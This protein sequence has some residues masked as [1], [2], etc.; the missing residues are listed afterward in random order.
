VAE[1]DAIGTVSQGVVTYNVK[2]SLDTQDERVKPGMSASASII[3]EIKQDVLLVSS[4]SIKS[5]NGTNYVEMLENAAAVNNLSASVSNNTGVSSS[6]L[7]KQQMIEIGLSND[8]MTEVTSGLKEGDQVIVR[9]I[10]PST[11]TSQTSSGQTI[12]QTSTR[13]SGSGAGF[14]R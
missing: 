11:S 3:T 13:T 10:T 9:T 6:T 5:S 7:P 14:P 4:S 1:V 12:F 8:S 2:I